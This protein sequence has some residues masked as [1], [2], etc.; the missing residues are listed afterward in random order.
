M[1]TKKDELHEERQKQSTRHNKK[2]FD[3]DNNEFATAQEINSKAYILFNWESPFS[4]LL[5]VL[6]Q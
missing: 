4:S 2:A 1:T 5:Y 6:F 3:N